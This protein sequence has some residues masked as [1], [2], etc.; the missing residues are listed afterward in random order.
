LGVVK[1]ENPNQW[2]GVNTPE[3]LVEADRRKRND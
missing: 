3:Q 2:F 1:L